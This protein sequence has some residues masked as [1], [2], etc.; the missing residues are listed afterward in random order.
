MYA[1]ISGKINQHLIDLGQAVNANEM[2]LDIVNNEQVSG[3][4]LC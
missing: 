4:G 3:T 2:L 1:T